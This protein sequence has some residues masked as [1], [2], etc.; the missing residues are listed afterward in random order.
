M[1]GIEG[2]SDMANACK[3]GR[4]LQEAEKWKMKHG[5][6]FETSKYVLIHFTR[7]SRQA[8]KAPVRIIEATISPS[9]EAKYLGV[10]F[11]EKLHFKTHLQYVT[12]KG[13]SAAMALSSIA[14]S[15]WGAQYKLCM[16]ALQC[17][18]SHPHRLCGSIWHRPKSDGK[19]MSHP[20]NTESHNN[21]KTPDENDPRML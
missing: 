5:A 13:T 7:N 15:N 21:P 6:Q 9:S 11:D 3:L 8:T 16:T 19:I 20:T 10:I 14:K 1:Y 4:M 12:K 18:Y 17:S 2:P